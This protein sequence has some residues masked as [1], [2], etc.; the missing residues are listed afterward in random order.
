MTNR[1]LEA[2][3]SQDTTLVDVLD[4]SQL[5]DVPTLKTEI[6]TLQHQQT[7]TKDELDQL[8]KLVNTN[9]SYNESKFVDLNTD[10]NKLSTTIDEL[11]SKISDNGDLKL[12]VSK[13]QTDFKVFQDNVVS[14]SIE[15]SSQ[16]GILQSTKLDKKEFYDVD[17]KLSIIDNRLSLI[18]NSI[19]LQKQSFDQ[20]NDR[21][22]SLEVRLVSISTSVNNIPATISN[23][24][25]L[26]IGDNLRLI[27]W[28][29]EL[30]TSYDVILEGPFGRE[31][32]TRD[33]DQRGNDTAIRFTA[34]YL[35]KPPIRGYS[36]ISFLGGNFKSNTY[37]YRQVMIGL[38]P[39]FLS[40]YNNKGI[41]TSVLII[42]LK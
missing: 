32:T 22:T 2:V 8:G 39:V 26:N 12:E 5:Y 33:N 34:K 15:I 40:D 17:D 41:K 27:F 7:N 14:E 37:M 9:Q 18:E 4:E 28:F 11:S 20:L 35:I 24:S 38:N 29:D 13:M 16:I 10:L 19:K 1:L 3:F 25:T 30:V 23:A 6:S 31:V 21:V 36:Y 42:K